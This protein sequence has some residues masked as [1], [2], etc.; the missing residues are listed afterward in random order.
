MEEKKEGSFFIKK[1]FTWGELQNLRVLLLIISVP[2]GQQFS[3]SN[4]INYFL[5]MILTDSMR[6]SRDL[7]LV[8]A[9]CAQCT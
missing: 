6:L 4:M 2:L 7:F 1:P 8:L 3:G 5:S 9:G